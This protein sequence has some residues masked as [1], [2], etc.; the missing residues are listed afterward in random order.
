MVRS[1]ALYPRAA[2]RFEAAGFEVADRLVLLRADLDDA[3]VRAAVAG[4]RRPGHP[5]DAA[6]PLRRR[7]GDRPRRVRPGWGH[8]AKRA[9]RDLPRHA[10]PRRPPSSR[11]THAGSA[12]HG[13][14]L[15]AFAIAGASS[16]HGYLQR[17]AVDPAAQR[18]GHGSA[19]TTD[20]LR[21]MIRRRLPDCLVNTS[22]DNAAA[23]ALYASLGFHA[24][25]RAAHC[26]ALRRTLAAMSGSFRRRPWRGSCLMSSPR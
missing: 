15:I 18:R 14:D 25:G 6:S 17:L 13:R 4:R 24:D 21:W 2:A 22:V 5:H 26:P 8:D 12:R 16:D 3:R 1:A 7:G 11:L 20:A 23:L 9:R 19:L 10:G